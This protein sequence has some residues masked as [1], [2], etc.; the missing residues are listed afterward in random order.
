MYEFMNNSEILCEF[1]PLIIIVLQKR[2]STPLLSELEELSPCS[3]IV[4][5]IIAIDYCDYRWLFLQVI[6]KIPNYL[7]FK[8]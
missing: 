3:I 8:H 2:I 4:I 1:S 7:V 6:I 5:N